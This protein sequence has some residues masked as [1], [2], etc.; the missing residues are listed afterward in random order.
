VIEVKDYRS[1][2][3]RKERALGNGYD[4]LHIKA[5]AYAKAPR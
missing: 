1:S 5:E 3:G 2:Y 4:E